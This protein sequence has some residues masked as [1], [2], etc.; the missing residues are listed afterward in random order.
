MSNKISRAVTI[1]L[2]IGCI[3]VLCQIII[4]GITRLTDSGLSITE[5]EIVKGTLP[6]LSETE[7]QVSFDK[8]KTF[9]K[10]QFESLHRDMTL[11]KFKQIYF[12]EYFHRLWARMMG[13]VFIIPL[14]WFL[15]RRKVEIPLL[16][17]LGIVILLASFSALF[18]WLM[19]ASGLNNDK[20][21][22]VNAYNLL[23]HLILASSLFSYLTYT[24]YSYSFSRNK[25]RFELNDYNLL[26]TI[27]IILFLQIAFGALM[28]GMKAALIFPYPFILAKWS[29][30]KT[31]LA[32]SP[33]LHLADW[34]DYEP[35]PLIKLIVQIVHRATAYILLILSIWFFISN[36]LKMF[37]APSFLIFYCI[38]LIQIILGIFT[39][40]YSIGKV[41]VFMGVLHQAIAF[42]VL[43]AYL[44]IVFSSKKRK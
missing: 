30:L 35:N 5:W 25:S 23:I 31:I 11:E 3:M 14:I 7:W 13:F 40:T 34:I 32:T 42:L 19:V 29:V 39:V 26:Y 9:A 24:F 37:I 8:Y 1:W 4:G 12:W 28:A 20:R 27:G 22:W 21:T 33:A 18:G 41:P 43:A 6:P 17:R 16:K 36:R 10:K 2:F 44:W 38:L 15:I